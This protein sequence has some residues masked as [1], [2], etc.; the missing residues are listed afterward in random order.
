MIRQARKTRRTDAAG[1]GEGEEG[2]AKLY[3]P[4]APVQWGRDGRGRIFQ[5]SRLPVK[6]SYPD[7]G[8]REKPRHPARAF[9]TAHSPLRDGRSVIIGLGKIQSYQ[10]FVSNKQ[11]VLIL[12]ASVVR[13]F[14]MLA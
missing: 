11:G 1:P 9:G 8:I 14:G 6:D 13:L 12:K 3:K 7:V 2:T 5:Y 4:T 10:W